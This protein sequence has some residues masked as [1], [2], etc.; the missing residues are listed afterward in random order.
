MSAMNPAWI[1]TLTA[2]QTI[3]E[4]C[5]YLESLPSKGVRNSVIDGLEAWFHV[6][7]KSLRTIRNI[8][9]TLHSSSLMCAFLKILS[10]GR[11]WLIWRPQDRWHRGQLSV[12]TW[13]SCNTY[14]L[15]SCPDH[16]CCQYASFQGT[17]SG[18]ILIISRGCNIFTYVSHITTV[19]TSWW[20]LH[21][22]GANGA[23]KNSW[24]RTLAKAWTCVGH[25]SQLYLP[26]TNIMTW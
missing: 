23:K 14:R 7:E 22:H 4:P 24:K 11:F 16:Q 8:V 6:P 20:D 17:E 15:W 5:V 21:W 25:L 1:H 19:Q 26:L 2:S 13:L 18:R 9:N 10:A 12:E 3:S